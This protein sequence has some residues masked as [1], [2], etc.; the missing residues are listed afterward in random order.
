LASNLYD[1]T[2]SGSCQVPNLRQETYRPTFANHS[3][4]QFAE[5]VRWTFTPVGTSNRQ[6]LGWSLP[7]SFRYVGV[8]QELP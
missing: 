6:V 1:E 3:E 2:K 5:H 7:M 4:Y 8:P